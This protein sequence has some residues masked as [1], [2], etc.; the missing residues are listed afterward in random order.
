MNALLA[1]CPETNEYVH[2]VTY[3][4]A[5][6]AT[7]IRDVIDVAASHITAVVDTTIGAKVSTALCEA[8]PTLEG[9]IQDAELSNTLTLAL[10]S[11][12]G[13]ADLKASPTTDL[14]EIALDETL[15]DY[16]PSEDRYFEIILG[17]G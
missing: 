13:D 17:E 3:E 5:E 1:R 10:A 9:Y 4:A 6:R 8:Y 15:G 16:L 7:Q 11:V 2:P 14:L 12:Y